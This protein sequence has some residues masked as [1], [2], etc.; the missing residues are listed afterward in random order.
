MKK[1]FLYNA[2]KKKL[3]IPILKI[4]DTFGIREVILTCDKLN[5][6]SSKVIKN[7]KGELVE[8]FYSDTFKEDIQKYIIKR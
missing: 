2:Y 8:E 3:V 5:I 7:C 6:A 4:C 1:I